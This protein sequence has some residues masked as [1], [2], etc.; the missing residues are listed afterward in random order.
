MEPDKKTTQEPSSCEHV[1]DYGGP[2]TCE[3]VIREQAEC[4]SHQA[5][6]IEAQSFVLKTLSD[7]FREFGVASTATTPAECTQALRNRLSDIACLYAVMRGEQKA[8][9]LLA[10]IEQRIPTETF[11]AIVV[12]LGGFLAPR[13]QKFVEE[14]AG[15]GPK[16]GACIGAAELITGMKGWVAHRPI[17]ERRMLTVHQLRRKCGELCESAGIADEGERQTIEREISAAIGQ[18]V[19][20]LSQLEAGDFS[21]VEKL[22]AERAQRQQHTIQ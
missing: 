9:S 22:F 7:L 16:S 12:D 17:F 10:E 6:C 13:L 18:D 15:D 1:I 4:I 11:T 20:A 3:Q 19:L 8:S 5:D 14:L 21:E 2:K